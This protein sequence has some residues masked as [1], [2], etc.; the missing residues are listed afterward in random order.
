MIILLQG[1]LSDVY[2]YVCMYVCVCV[3]LYVCMYVQ[4][5][6]EFWHVK[7]NMKRY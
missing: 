2:M 6:P 5:V 3:Y 1:A 4:T 7:K